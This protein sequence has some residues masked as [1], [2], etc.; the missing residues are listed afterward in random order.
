[1]GAGLVHADPAPRQADDGRHREHLPRRAGGARPR[2]RRPRHR[3]AQLVIPSTAHPAL[4]QG[5]PLPRRRARSGCRSATTAGPTSAATAAAIDDRTGARRRLGA[6]L[7]VRRHR[8]DP[9]AGGAGRRARRPVPHRRLPRRLAAAVLG[10]A[11]RAGPAVGLPGPG[12]HVDLGR[13]PQVRLL[14][15]RAP[16][17]SCTATR[18]LLRA[19]SSCTTTGPAACTARPRRPARARRRPIAGAWATHQPPRRGRLPAPG[20]PGP[21][22]RPPRSGPASRRST[23]CGS[24]ASPT[25]ACSSSRADGDGR[26][27][28]RRGRRDGR[29]GLAPRPPAGRPAPDG[30]ARTTP[31]VAD[32]VPRRPGRRGGAA[33][34]A[35]R[36]EEAPY[37]GVG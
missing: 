10:A 22:R 30:V 7:P 12:R 17:C 19:S 32:R 9:R 26:R 33:T 37:G 3:R 23:G 4:R 2:P 5:L 28:R 13:R 20:R 34:A 11:R 16:R 27:H 31:Q 25:W 18:D 29:P 14:R 24:P 15:S 21:R 8:P 36:G 35:S 1:M 6:L